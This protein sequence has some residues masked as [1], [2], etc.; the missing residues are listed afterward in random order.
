MKLNR[1]FSKKNTKKKNALNLVITIVS[2]W[3]VGVVLNAFIMTKQTIRDS[4]GM[5][6]HNYTDI[7]HM[8]EQLEQMQEQLNYYIDEK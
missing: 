3:V 2:L 4:W 7:Y 5:A 1:I 6:R 8:Q